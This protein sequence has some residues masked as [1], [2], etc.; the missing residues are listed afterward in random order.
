MIHVLAIVTTLPGQREAVLE[1]FRANVPAVHAEKG[2]IEYVPVIDAADGGPS[3]TRLGPD[4]F[5]VV[6]K[7]S[8]MEAL[9]AH[10]AAPHMAAYAAKV[11]G[12]LASRTIHVLTPAG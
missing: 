8:S 1:I 4:T 12:M 5:C 2:C 10:A 9:R 3:Q 6:E 11:K 7:W